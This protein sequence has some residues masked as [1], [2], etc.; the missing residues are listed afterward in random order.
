[1][2]Q[3]EMAEEGVDLGRRETC[4]RSQQPSDL[5]ARNLNHERA[6]IKRAVFEGFVR[7]YQLLEGQPVFLLECLEKVGAANFLNR[8]AAYR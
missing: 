3:A 5:V 4:L 6:S 8:F 2:S 1:M 7:P